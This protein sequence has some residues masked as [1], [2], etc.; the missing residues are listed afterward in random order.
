MKSLIVQRLAQNWKSGVTVALV[1]IPLA[2]SLAVASHTTP[3]VGIITAIWAGLIAAIFGG[4][5]FNI[6]GPT[7]ALS[8]F[9]ASYA[10]SHGAQM[11]PALA[12]MAG[13]FIIIAYF[14]R[15]DRYIV[16]VPGSVV[17]GFTLGIAIIIMLNQL[18]FILGLSHLSVHPHLMR[19]ALEAY[20]HLPEMS[21]W[22]ASIFAAFLSALFI[23]AR[24]FKRLPAIILVT[25]FGIVLGLCGLP[26][27][28][29][30]AKFGSVRG[31]ICQFPSIEYD[32][33]LLLAGLTVA[34]VAM[35]ETLI[36]AKIADGLTRTRYKARK[37]L[38]GLGLANVVS[39]LFGG[40]PATAALARTTLN[41]RSGAK[42]KTSQ[43]LSSLCIAVCAIVL[44]P[45][46]SY[47]PLAVIAAILVFV[48][49]GM[50][51]A[52]HFS[53][54][55]AYDKINF[56]V[57][58]LVALI[59]VVRD[60]II[61]ILF[62]SAVSLI[63]FMEKLSHGYLELS[64]IKSSVIDETPD[65]VTYYLAGPLGYINARAHLSYF[66][67][68]LEDFK[69][70]RITLSLRKL[71]FIDLD[72]IDVISEIIEI[73]QE[74]NISVALV[75]VNQQVEQMLREQSP[76]CARLLSN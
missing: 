74:K 36:S 16:F 76:Q 35:L 3:V 31:A 60:P 53:R 38:F 22:A 68:H 52:E 43:G 46:F 32:S 64:G 15:L 7:G 55:F 29:L 6:I 71:Y 11:L 39:G 62:G 45:Y 40:M 59:T 41:I 30:H 69:N 23:A 19:N 27:E 67:S 73:L 49:I 1:S 12:V 58:C 13:L 10:I 37:E 24:L 25:P 56:A 33:S 47:L 72:G 28:T 2:I 9:L 75:G 65:A 18:S 50:I 34:F 4:S 42:H 51:E 61:G 5:N 44:L 8:G 66:E 20:K 48:A 14:L 21:W 70:K 17:H 63:L 57:S 26:L 54:L